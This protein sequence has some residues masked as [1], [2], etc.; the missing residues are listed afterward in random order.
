M[1]AQPSLPPLNLNPP[2]L[3]PSPTDTSHSS[4][5]KPLPSHGEHGKSASFRIDTKAFFL[6][7]DGGRMDSC[8]ITEKRG[9]YQGSI[10]VGRLGLDWIIACLVELGRWDF[11]KQHFLKRVHENYKILECSSR[12]NKGGFFVEI[13]EYH[14]GARRGCLRVPEGFHKGGWSF[15]ERKLSDFFL[16][17]LVSKPGKEVVA[18]GGR[19]VKPTSNP[20]NHVWKDIN[21]HVKLGN[22]LDLEKQFSKLVGTLYQKEGFGGFDFIPKTNISTHHV[23]GRPVRASSFKWTRAHFSLNIS[24]DLDGKGQHVVM[25]ANFVQPKTVKAV[26]TDTEFGPTRQTQ[27]GPIKQAQDDLLAITKPTQSGDSTYLKSHGSTRSCERGEGSGSHV[28]VEKSTPSAGELGGDV[29]TSNGGSVTAVQEIIA[30]MVCTGEMGGVLS[31]SDGGS[32]MEVQVG[33]VLIGCTGSSTDDLATECPISGAMEVSCLLNF[34][35]HPSFTDTT[36]RCS[37]TLVKRAEGLCHQSLMEQNRS[38]PTS[39]L[40]SDSFEEEKLLLN[41]VNPTGSDTD[42]KD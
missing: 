25:W 36:G 11:S 24:V 33:F 1:P 6:A 29:L 15:L 32:D 22:D 38:S 19:F 26:L 17:K 10:R 2:K 4:Q 20:R 28:C 34:V 41:W 3:P 5:A 35:D 13:S 23:S 39:K 12:L 37:T 14:N 27:G 18:G 42:E 30:P 9:R 21:G 7:F 16:G 40:V 31:N 8:S